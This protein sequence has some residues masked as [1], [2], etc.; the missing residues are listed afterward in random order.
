MQQ[1]TESTGNLDSY[2][3]GFDEQNRLAGPWGQ[4]E[5]VRTQQIIQRHLK[6]PPAIVLDVGGAA[7]RYACWLAREGYQVH[8]VD[9][10]SKHIQQARAASAAQP[11]NPISS[12][13]VGDA[14]QLEFDAGYADGVLL[15]GPLYH[16]VEEQDRLRAMSEAYRVLKSGGTLFAVGIS[17]FA[18]TIDGLKEGYFLDPVFR[19]IMV[20]DLASGQHRNPTDNPAYFTDTCFHHPEELRAEVA[21]AGFESVTL[22]AVEGI[23]Y[24]MQAFDENWAIESYRTFLLGLIEK[25]EAEP[26]LIGASPHIMCVAAKP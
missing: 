20:R 11:E 13:R 14:R 16:L 15:M 4:I 6:A 8:L 5:Y 22:F 19:E 3:E 18:S 24:M 10:V 23:S 26:S 25:I 17:R 1:S 21:H 9:P 7:G 2:Y 12:C